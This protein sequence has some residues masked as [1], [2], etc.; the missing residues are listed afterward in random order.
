MEEEPALQD[1]G[2][3][4]Q[5]LENC[6]DGDGEPLM[7]DTMGDLPQEFFIWRTDNF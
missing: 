4:Y 3:R 5:H 1:N 7:I 6:A 2:W